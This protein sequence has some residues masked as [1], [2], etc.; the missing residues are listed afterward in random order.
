MTT[1][2]GER[3]AIMTIVSAGGGYTVSFKNAPGADPLDETISGITIEGN[4]FGFKRT[5]GIEQ[6]QIELNYAGTVEGNVLTGKV[7]SQ[8]GEFDLKGSRAG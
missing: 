6:G 1:P 4:S 2:I 5:V 8:F 7:A 3:K